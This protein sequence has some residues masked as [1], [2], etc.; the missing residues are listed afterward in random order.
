VQIDAIDV[1]DVSAGAGD[2]WFFMGDSITAF[3]FGR[4]VE[5]G[6]GFAE[7]VHQ[8]HASYD[9]VVINGGI[10]GEKADDGVRHLDDWI[11]QNPDAHF[12]AI[13]YG[14]NDAAGD[15][16]DVARFK[17]NLLTIVHRLQGVG[18]VPILSKIPFAS[19][20]K[21]PSIAKLNAV[22]DEVRGDNSLP[23]GPDLYS[24]FLDH[25][26]QLRD[27]IH[28]DDKGIESINRLW[29]EAVDRLYAP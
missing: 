6:L 5:P 15:T 28:P 8:R 14:T 20:G 26:D 22:I 9:P 17:N 23:A 16:V 1:H 3:A 10:G 27:G 24:W 12:W 7:R 25:P 4:S 13:A 18:R 11:G 21:H 2:T 19:D 29:A